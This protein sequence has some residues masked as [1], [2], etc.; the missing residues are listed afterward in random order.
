MIWTLVSWMKISPTLVTQFFFVTFK[1]LMVRQRAY[2]FI[3]GLVTISVRKWSFW[4]T[5]PGPCPLAL[6]LQTSLLPWNI[7]QSHPY[8]WSKLVQ[9]EIGF[10]FAR[11]DQPDLVPLRNQMLLCPGDILSSSNNSRSIARD[12]LSNREWDRVPNIR[13]LRTRPLIISFN[14]WMNNQSTN[15]QGDEV[16]EQSNV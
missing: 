2:T 12:K 7:L 9:G 15:H 6:S 11:L 14:P 3:F 8:W 13:I 16:P 5:R 4:R 1:E 10:W